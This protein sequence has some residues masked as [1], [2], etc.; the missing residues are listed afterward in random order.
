MHLAERG[1]RRRMVLEARKPPLPV[2]AELGHHAPL[3]EGPAH[4]RRVAL[5]LGEFLGVF[6]RQRVG[7]GRQQLG[8]LHDRA[9]QAAEGGREL[10]RTAGAIGF[11]PHQPGRGNPRCDPAHIGADPR[12]TRRAGGKAVRFGIAVG[13]LGT[14]SSRGCADRRPTI[15]A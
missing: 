10:D 7:D 5:Q 2:G 3:D 12:I 13:Q 15:Y 8:D 4:R 6:R 11:A 1:G 14:S 9:L